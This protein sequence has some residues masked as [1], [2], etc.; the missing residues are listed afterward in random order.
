MKFA[1]NFERF[2]KISLKDLVFS[3][4]VTR[5]NVFTQMH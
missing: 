5:K 2:E 3:K 4:S 1:L